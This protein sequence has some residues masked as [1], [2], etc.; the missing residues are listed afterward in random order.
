MEQLVIVLV[1]IAIA[2]GKFLLQK[3]DDPGGDITP[4]PPARRP[5]P[6]PVSR[7][8]VQQE[9]EEERMRRFM[10]ALGMPA[11]GAAPPRKVVRTTVQ[12][13]TRPVISIRRKETPPAPVQEPPPAQAQPPPMTPPAPMEA[14]PSPVLPAESSFPVTE[15]EPAEPSQ[16]ALPVAPPPVMAARTEPVRPFDIRSLLRS[17]DSMRAAMV[18]REI[19]GPPRGLE[20]YH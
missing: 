10:E 6:R 17:P 3:R 7:P 8:Q 4:M 16:P 18:L 15:P 19:I 12:V 20:S 2:V 5:S 9:S 1:F 13:K 11:T 14:F